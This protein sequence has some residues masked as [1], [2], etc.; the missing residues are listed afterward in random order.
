[1]VFDYTGQRLVSIRE[2]KKRIKDELERVK[3]LKIVGK[4]S[5]WITSTMNYTKFHDNDLIWRLPR[6]GK[7][8]KTHQRLLSYDIKTI[9]TLKSIPNAQLP[10]IRGI[11]A[12]HRQATKKSLPGSSPNQMV[13][14]RLSNNPYLS[15]YGDEWE[16]KIKKSSALPVF[17]PVS[18]LVDFVRDESLHQEDCFFN[19]DA[20]SLMTSKECTQCMRSTECYGT[21]MNVVK[22]YQ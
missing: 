4:Q 12:L 11:S 18:D 1:M 5:K 13:D 3:K 15:K 10:P 2:Y 17:C 7:Q 20:L 9:G 19:H 14:H 22:T 21:T 8:S 16:E 6:V